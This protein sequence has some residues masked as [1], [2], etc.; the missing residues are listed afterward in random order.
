MSSLLQ[1]LSES[2]RDKTLDI[3]RGFAL[4]GVLFIFCVS[5]N[6]PSY[7]YTS[8]YFDEVLSWFK[9]I[10]IESRMYTMLIIIFWHWLSRSTGE[11]QTTKQIPGTCFFK[12]DYWFAAP[13]IYSC[14]SSK[15]TGYT[16]FLRGCRCSSAFGSECQ[17][18]TVIVIHGN[19]IL[20]S[21]ACDTI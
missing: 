14:D 7:G 15:H 4:A 9:W 2:N 19:I 8:S 6:A 12:T 10:F 18:K 13:R 16:Y 21:R 11:S 20:C 5:D 17:H 3:L 1:P